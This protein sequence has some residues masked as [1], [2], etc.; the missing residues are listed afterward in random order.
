M[1][2]LFLTLLLLIILIIIIRTNESFYSKC[3]A[4]LLLNAMNDND[5]NAGD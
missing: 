2:Q 5:E 3:S 1:I 4:N